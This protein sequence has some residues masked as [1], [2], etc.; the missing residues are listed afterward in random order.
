MKIAIAQIQAL[1]GNIDSNIENHKKLIQ[2][3]VNNQ[4]NAIFFSELSLT[5]YEPELAQQLVLKKEDPILST[6][7]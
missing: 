4:V 1:K 2:L 6:F 7:Q 5:S 3:A